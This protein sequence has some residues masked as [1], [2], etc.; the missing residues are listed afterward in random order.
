MIAEP[1]ISAVAA[2]LADPGRA[3]MLSAL[4]DGRS[5][6]AGELAKIAGVTAQTASSHLH[7]LLEA[8]FISV[9]RQGRH[10]YYRLANADVAHAVETLGA[11]APMRQIES[12]RQSEKARALST[13]RTCYDHLA[14]ALSLRI[15]DGLVSA[16]HLERVDG[17]FRVTASGTDALERLG[18]TFSE[19]SCRPFARACL[20]WTERRHHIAGTLGAALLALFLERRWVVRITGSRAVRVTPEGEAALR[21]LSK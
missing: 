4:L 3:A 8:N 15:A 6:P 19:S 16:G 5:L 17:S 21:A 20:D 9:E 14:G 11:I 13:A 12:L 7:R 18:L 2:L 10:R 1:D